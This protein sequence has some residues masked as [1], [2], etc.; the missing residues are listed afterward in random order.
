MADLKIN[1]ATPQDIKLGSLDVLKIYQGPTLVWPI[2][3]GLPWLEE[4][5]TGIGT[6][7]VFRIND[8]TPVNQAISIKVTLQAK[9]FA[10]DG[11]TK[12]NWNSVDM[13]NVADF[14]T[15]IDTTGGAVQITFTTMNLLLPEFF[16]SCTMRCEIISM[17]I[18]PLPVPSYIDI[19]L[20]GPSPE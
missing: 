17:G 10:N 1:G 3:S 15:L 20:Y 8:L 5:N 2:T 14:S 6:S 13:F 12:V 18:D 11:V 7:G 9:S 16:D 4:I 19:N